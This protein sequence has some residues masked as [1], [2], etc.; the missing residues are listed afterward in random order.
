MV[1]LEAVELNK[2][3]EEMRW[4]FG[5]GTNSFDWDLSIKISVLFGAGTN[6]L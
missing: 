2:V 1:E 4:Q 5:A 6:S 3:A